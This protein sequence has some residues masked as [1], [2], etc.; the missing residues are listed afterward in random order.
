[1]DDSGQDLGNEVKHS[2][3]ARRR[4]GQP[5]NTNAL[6]HGRWTAV[7]ITR[8]KLSVARLKA[9]AHLAHE[10]RLM[11]EEGRNRVA[12][13]RQDQIMLLWKLDP[14]LIAAVPARYLKV[15]K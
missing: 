13:L 15:Q 5:G 12:A 7:A 6:R 14:A 4:G 2:A 8:R 3:R 9:L 1:M 10:F 11:C